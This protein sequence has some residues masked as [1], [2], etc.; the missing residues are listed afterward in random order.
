M[1][2][3]NKLKKSEIVQMALVLVFFISMTGMDSENRI[4]CVI[5]GFASLIGAI[6]C[7]KFRKEKPNGNI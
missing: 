4:P 6:I 1:K 3:A 7:N 5:I 2:G